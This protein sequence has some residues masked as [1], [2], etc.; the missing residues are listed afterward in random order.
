MQN[1]FVFVFRKRAPMKWSRQKK[2]VMGT[3]SNDSSFLPVGLAW[4]FHA[5]SHKLSWSNDC[6]KF[7]VH[8]FELP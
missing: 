5:S 3:D 2:V 6:E 1:V 4:S 8:A 7:D